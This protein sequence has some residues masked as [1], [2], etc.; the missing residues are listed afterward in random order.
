MYFGL[1]LFADLRL[2]PE[3]YDAALCSTVSLAVISCSKL[4][5]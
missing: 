3:Y 2:A 4:E 5:C 1:A